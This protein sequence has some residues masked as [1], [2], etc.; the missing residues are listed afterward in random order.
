MDLIDKVMIRGAELTFRPARNLRRFVPYDIS[1]AY[2][3][4]IDLATIPEQVTLLPFL[5]TVAPIVWAIGREYEVDVL[6][7]RVARSFEQMR[8]ELRT[9]YPSLTWSGAI[10]PRAL[11]APRDPAP[12]HLTHAALFSGGVDST[13]TALRYEGKNQL[14]ISVW[15][16]DVRLSDHGTWAKIRAR[17]S[18]FAARHG[19]GFAT[20]RSNFKSIK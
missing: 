20:V 8:A 6:D 14:L 4:A 2:D 5:W 9:M 1:V 7:P 3:P 19:G 11:N 13:L 16:A 15:G 17:N 18:A 12:T 10:R